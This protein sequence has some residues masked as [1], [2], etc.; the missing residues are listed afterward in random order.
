[1]I[2]KVGCCPTRS[3]NASFANNEQASLA[4]TAAICFAQAEHNL[5]KFKLYIN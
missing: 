3:N 5:I 2:N 4:F 1:M